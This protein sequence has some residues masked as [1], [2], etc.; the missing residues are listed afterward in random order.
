MCEICKKNPCDTHC[1]NY[2]PP[3]STYYCSICKDQIENGEEYIEND[4]GE[5]AH[6]E[7]FRGTKDLL[8]WLRYDIRTKEDSNV[9]RN[10]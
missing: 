2:M 9:H 10:Y 6:Y 3:K 1:P 7:C 5:Y 4:I 8:K